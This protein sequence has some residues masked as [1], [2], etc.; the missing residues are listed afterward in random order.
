MFGRLISLFTII[1]IFHGVA[2]GDQDS[3]LDSCMVRRIE[4]PSIFEGLINTPIATP[5]MVTEDN[6]GLLTVSIGETNVWSQE[7][8]DWVSLHD[9]YWTGRTVRFSKKDSGIVFQLTMANY[10]GSGRKGRGPKKATRSGTLSL[11]DN[12]G[13][14][15]PMA[16]IKCS[17]KPGS[18]SARW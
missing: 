6:Q 5:V 4:N 7:N 12:Q 13:K 10:G 15:I 2:H 14:S 8:Q 17:R 11:L 18:N 9:K 3:V 1:S 16:N